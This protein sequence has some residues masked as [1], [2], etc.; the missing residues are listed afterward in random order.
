M[1][2]I[3][4]GFKIDDGNLFCTHCGAKAP[5]ME[6]DVEVQKNIPV[7]AIP[8]AEMPAGEV[9]PEA[10]PAQNT[11]AKKVPKEEIPADDETVS[12]TDF[13]DEPVNSP[14]EEDDE[15]TVL[16][17]DFSENAFSGNSNAMGS[18]GTINSGS[19]GTT[20]SY[21]SAPVNLSKPQS[22]DSGRSLPPHNYGSAN[23]HTSEETT[24]NRTVPSASSY[25]NHSS[26]ENSPVHT[27]RINPQASGNNGNRRAAAAPKKK[28]SAGLIIA[29]VFLI[30]AILAV[31]GVGGYF[32]YKTYFAESEYEVT[33]LKNRHS[34]D[35]EED[36]TRSSSKK[37]KKKDSAET[38]TA[39]TSEETSE[40]STAKDSQKITAQSTAASTEASTAAT[41]EAPLVQPEYS[42]N[43]SENYDLSRYMKIPVLNVNQSSYLVQ[44]DSPIINYGSNAFDGDLKTS[45]QDGTTGNG[46]GEWLFISMDKKYN[47][48]AL[49]FDLGN[50]RS[51]EW[52]Y[53][54]NRPSN[55]G[56]LIG[57]FYYSVVFPDQCK[58]FCVSFSQPVPADTIRFTVEG[59]YPGTAYND[60]TIAEIGV[61]GN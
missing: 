54:N 24:Q 28:S 20:P 13:T 51:D 32:A 34:D 50:H 1:F 53:K 42:L 37:K 2:C 3:K 39:E 15:R 40:K 23:P 5:K 52:Y 36:E 27:A 31:L 48:S 14:E 60:M 55:I 9:H 10:I 33:S 46:V 11:P 25:M 26:Y 49:T 22:A 18:S 21:H 43:F 4:C 6:P 59:C 45:W 44:K 8:A 41:T 7:N 57:G 19:K 17:D 30:L 16:A 47:V 35:A 12:I 38:E 61:Y 56:I 58:E 29:I